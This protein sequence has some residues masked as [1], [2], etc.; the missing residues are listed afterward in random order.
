MQEPVR[1][2]VPNCCVLFDS[3]KLFCLLKSPPP[4][5]SL[6]CIARDRKE[7]IWN[8][9]FCAVKQLTSPNAACCNSIKLIEKIYR[10]RILIQ[11]FIL[12]IKK[13]DVRVLADYLFQLY[14][15]VIQKVFN[16]FNIMDA[17]TTVFLN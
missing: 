17:E 8:V 1:N 11:P 15:V 6:F 13:N 14:N 5:S 2:C 12:L 4:S 16:I 7:G 9:P 3:K 10:K